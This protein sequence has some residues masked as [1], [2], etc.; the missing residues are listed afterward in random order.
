MKAIRR[1]DGQEVEVVLS[2]DKEYVDLHADKDGLR[3]IYTEGALIIEGVTDWDAFRRETASRVLAAF[4]GYSGFYP[5]VVQVAI[6]VTEDLVNELRD[7]R[8]ER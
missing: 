2:H 5:G 8:K 7:G 1:S 3:S 4:I 6:E